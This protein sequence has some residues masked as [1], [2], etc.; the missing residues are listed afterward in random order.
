M[1][2]ASGSSAEIWYKIE[3]SNGVTPSSDS[4]ASTTLASAVNPGA[5]LITVASGTGIA[6]GEILRVGNSQNMEFVKVDSSYVSGTTVPLDANTK[7]NYRHESGEDV[8]ETDPTGNW[9]KLGNVRS[10][11][12]SGGR[13]LQR[14]QAL[15]GSRVLSNFR[16]GNY[17]AGADMTVELDIESA[18]LFYLHALNNDY[19]SAGTTQGTTPVNTTLAQAAAKGDTQIE[20]SSASEMATGIYLLIGTGTGAEIVKVG[21]Y[22]SGTTIDLDPDAHPFGLRKSHAN[23]AAVVEKIKP[24]THTIYRGSTIPEGISILLRFTDIESLMLI[25]GNKISNLTLNVDPSDLPQLNMTVVGKAFQILSENIFGTPTAIPNTPYV[26]WEAN[27]KVDNNTLTTNQLENLSLVIE[28]TIQGNF[29]VG[30]PIKGAITP[31]EGSVSGSFT[32]Q[33]N[34]QQFAEKTVAGTETQL[35]FIWTYI[36]DDNHQVTLSVPKAKFEGTP[37]PGVGSKDPITDEKS[38]LGRLD[39]GSSPETDITAT[40]KNNQPTVEFMVE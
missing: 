19:Y 23:G 13:E 17:D 15:S 40:V 36:G 10:F 21:T 37:H 31:G 6:A 30:S 14:S 28:N 27:V 38:F 33:Y 5:T 2:Q 22:T 3:Q 11:T 12:P 7:L 32:Y 24:F 29:V 9:F 4:G 16:E 20:V 35:D 1:A 18:G 34:N 8:K 26:H 25:R 39:T